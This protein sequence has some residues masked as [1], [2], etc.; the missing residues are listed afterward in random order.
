MGDSEEMVA[1]GTPL[2]DVVYETVLLAPGETRL[3]DASEHSDP[4]LSLCPHPSGSNG[5]TEAAMLAGL[6][7]NWPLLPGHPESQ[8]KSAP[9]AFHDG[10]GNGTEAMTASILPGGGFHV[11]QQQQQSQRLQVVVGSPLKFHCAS[12]IAGIQDSFWAYPITTVSNIPGWPSTPT[13]VT[14][15]FRDFVALSEVLA[16]GLPGYFLPRRPHRAALEARR[17]SPRFLEDRR[18]ALERYLTHLGAHPAAAASE[19]LQ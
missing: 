7:G 15:R 6:P 10:L 13:V 14:R 5:Y 4:P 8:P 1:W 12:S 17:A 18:S 9:P 16:A 19:A 2:G 11:Q 3:G